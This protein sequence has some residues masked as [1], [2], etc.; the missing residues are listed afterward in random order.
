VS[1]CLKSTNGIRISVCWEKSS[2]LSSTDYRN[3]DMVFI[4]L[5]ISDHLFCIG[6][7]GIRMCCIWKIEYTVAQLDLENR[8]PNSFPALLDIFLLLSHKL[9]CSLTDCPMQ[10]R[11]QMFIKGSTW[12]LFI[13]CPSICQIKATMT[14]YPIMIL[15]FFRYTTWK[16]MF[17]SFMELQIWEI[18]LR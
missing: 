6:Q 13:I 10:D 3:S 11:D 17:D 2:Y 15:M 18:F 8:W 4:T 1:K 9:L 16:L 12:H 7:L 14:F 5:I